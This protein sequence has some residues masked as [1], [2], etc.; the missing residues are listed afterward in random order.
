MD[1]LEGSEFY[2]VPVPVPAAFTRAAVCPYANGV[3]PHS[4]GLVGLQAVCLGL[5]QR[6]YASV[7]AQG[8]H[9]AVGVGKFV[10]SFYPGWS[11]DGGQLLG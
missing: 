6:S 10:S 9:N 11:A 1:Y 8:G 2:P 5:P 4:R 7:G 3:P